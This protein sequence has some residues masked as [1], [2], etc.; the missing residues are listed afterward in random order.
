VEGDLLASNP[1]DGIRR[2]RDGRRG[3]FSRPRFTVWTPAELLD[4]LG[5]AEGNRF[6]ALWR[7]AVA[8][9]AP[10]GELLGL[11]WLGYSAETRKLD[12]QQVVPTRGGMSISPC[13][14]KGSH[15][16]ITLDD[17]T[18]QAFEKHRDRQLAEREEEAR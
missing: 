13:K 4:L 11:T 18:A 17:E 2:Q 9:G 15:R 12:S 14:T 6:E 7:V 5:A 1:V 3:A 16:T 8:T 10:R